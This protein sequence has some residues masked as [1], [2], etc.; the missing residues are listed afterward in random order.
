M[1]MKNPNSKHETLSIVSSNSR[2]EKIEEKTK[3][4][5]TNSGGQHEGRIIIREL[6][7]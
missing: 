7:L 6:S 2:E 4:L 5:I 3:I 1:L